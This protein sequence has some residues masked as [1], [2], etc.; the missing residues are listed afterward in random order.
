MRKYIGTGII[1]VSM[2]SMSLALGADGDLYCLP[3]DV[4]FDGP[5]A[6]VT[7]GEDS[8]ITSWPGNAVAKWSFEVPEKMKR[9]MLIEYAAQRGVP[10][11]LWVNGERV[12]HRH[13]PNGDDWSDYRLVSMGEL[14]LEAGTHTIELKTSAKHVHAF[15][16]FRQ[17]RFT[18]AAAPPETDMFPKLY[19]N[20]GSWAASMANLRSKVNS[21]EIVAYRTYEGELLEFYLHTDD[22][23]QMWADYPH[24]MDWFLQDNQIHGELG[25]GVYDA[26]KDFT[27]YFDANRS[28]ELEVKLV[29]E[30]INDLGDKGA[31]VAKKLDALVK[32]GQGAGSSELLQLYVDAC[33]VRRQD[34]IA[35][36]L[37]ETQQIIYATHQNFGSVAGI[38]TQ[39]ETEGLPVGESQL[40][41]ID[42][43]PEGNGHFAKDELLFDSKGGIVRDPEL[44]FDAKRL[45]FAWRKT[46]RS[47]GTIAESA[48]ETGNYC[49]YEMDL[50]SREIRALTDDENYG[51]DIEPT[52]L[53]NG[54]IIFNSSRIV[55][56]VTCGWGDCSNFF[57]MNKDGKYQRRV[58]FDQTN[59]TQ[60]TMLNDGRV[61]YNRR[62]YN[63][64]GQTYAHSLFAMNPDGTNQTEF[65][66]N[67]TAEPT[68]FQHT[69]AVPGSHKVLGIAGGYHTSQGGKL[70][71]IDIHKGRQK[72]EGLEFIGWDHEKKRRGGDHYG[73][74]GDQYSYPYPFSEND[75]LISY[76]PLG[77]YM[78]T[79]RGFVDKRKEPEHMRYKLYYMQRDG[80]RELL[81]ANRDLSVLQAIPVR[82]RPVPVLKPSKVDYKKDTGTMYVQNVYH[83]PSAEGIEPGSIDK[84]RVI[85]LDYKPVTL[86]G[87][88][89]G[90]P[91]DEIGPG[92][93]YSSFGVHTVTPVG[94]GSATFDAKRILGEVDVH[95]DGS[96]M[97]EVPARKPIYLQLIDKN[98]HAAQTM[99]SWATLMPG[100]N[101]SCI[102][103]H[104]DKKD[105]PLPSVNMAI[106]S[107]PQQIKPFY[108]TDKEGFSYA[109][110]IQPI[111]D[112]HCIECHAPGKEAKEID[113]TRTP[114]FDLVEERGANTMKRELYQSYLTLLKVGRR[115]DGKMGSGMP[116]EWVDYYTRLATVEAT[117][118]YY[119]GSA[120]SGM[121]EMLEKGHHDVKLSKREKDLIA[122]WIDLNVPFIGEYDE[123]NV[124]TDK[125][126][127]FYEQRMKLREREA[128]IEKRNIM[129]FIKDGQP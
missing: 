60:A 43:S 21:D 85:E 101:F 23:K 94:V 50:A 105:A 92:K 117:P 114:V 129:E 112:K 81:A 7:R 14:E 109:K 57:L 30:V 98:G 123:N 102:G 69:R 11:E 64:R 12:L 70:V 59:T 104:E 29:K 100:E 122:A 49:I 88:L 37:N 27:N 65:Y 113:L 15:I 38:Y 86:G 22:G 24:E 119:A 68:S 80:T 25:S 54:D 45:L 56:D 35:P 90:P 10:A 1:A 40:R 53:P 103:C 48:P 17:L 87:A 72:Y 77:G 76:S 127:A 107:A 28:A 96:A 111:W 3:K 2:L 6:H 128:E 83:G 118:P 93:K 121:I 95:E 75:F 16:N 63:D 120:N 66:G 19:E 5:K 47:I 78:T 124:W 44:S 91:R 125:E 9:N 71:E 39:T 52:Y 26:R 126:K 115:P 62:D 41:I 110:L 13:L 51:A 31:K 79:K 20:K 34:R 84:I 33:K 67:Q 61:V 89:W 106:R 36:L 108:E 73:R 74:E 42:L 18:K 97:F 46:N 82:E 4:T 58:G 116:N 55:Q 32:S 8:Q 99:R